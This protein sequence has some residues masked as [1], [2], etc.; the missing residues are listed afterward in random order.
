LVAL[1]AGTPDGHDGVRRVVVRDV[2]RFRIVGEECRALFKIGADDKRSWFRG[3]MYSEARHK[4][5]PEHKRLRTVHRALT[6]VRGTRPNARTASNV[7]AVFRM[8]DYQVWPALH[9]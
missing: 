6:Q 9:R 2:V 8:R 5:L 1:P 3:P 4:P 7:T